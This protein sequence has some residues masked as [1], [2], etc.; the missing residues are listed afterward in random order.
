MTIQTTDDLR[1]LQDLDDARTRGL[2][3]ASRDALRSVADW[4]QAFVAQPN[5]QLGRPGTVCPFVPGS[6]D[7]RALWLAAEP[8]GDGG[9]PRL[10]EVL[11]R[12]KRQL[13]D[14]GPP[15]DG[16]TKYGVI[17]VIFPDLS[18]QDAPSLF[19]E[20]L[21]QIAVPSFVEDGIVFGPF[22]D[23]NEG[24][25]IY[26]EQFRPFQS[27]VPFL[28]IRHGV[29]SDWKFFLQTEDWFGHWARRFGE[30]GTHALAAE[31]R[32]LPWNAPRG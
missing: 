16:G 3:G 19:S 20:A 25:A 8:L 14:V 29:V 1:L 11:G 6:L 10:V 17:V 31:L 27:P 2:P 30:A 26:N 22:Y 21:E 18:A 4:I 15:E 28:F 12:Y 23:G 32:Q 7:R 9:V 24:T 5:E 13:L